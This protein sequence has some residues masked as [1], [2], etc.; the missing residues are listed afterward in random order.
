MGHQFVGR[1][2]IPADHL[3]MIMEWIAVVN[4]LFFAKNERVYHRNGIGGDVS[5]PYKLLSKQ[6]D[7]LKFERAVADATARWVCKFITT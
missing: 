6:P 7:K 4:A 3:P 1:G 5:P 2:Y